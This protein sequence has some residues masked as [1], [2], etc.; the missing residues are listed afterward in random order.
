MNFIQ[1]NK[2]F[3]IKQLR[4]NIL[5]LLISVGILMYSAFDRFKFIYVI[6]ELYII[7]NL[8]LNARFQNFG[9]NKNLEKNQIEIFLIYISIAFL[10]IV[11]SLGNIYWPIYFR[12]IIIISSYLI[13][14]I[15][16][17]T[18]SHKQVIILFF[19]TCLGFLLDKRGLR[20]D[21]IQISVNLFQTSYGEN[22]Y[23][24]STYY[25]IFLIY[26]LSQKKYLLSIL[27]IILVLLAGKRTI[28]FGLIPPLIAFIVFLK[29]NKSILV[30]LYFLFCSIIAININNILSQFFVLIGIDDIDP[31]QVLEGRIEPNLFLNKIIHQKSLINYLF[32]N[33]AGQADITLSIYR[34]MQWAEQYPIGTNPHNDFLKIFYDYGIIGIIS[35]AFIFYL[36]GSKTNAAGKS[37]LVFTATVMITENPLIYIY[38]W[39]VLLMLLFSERIRINPN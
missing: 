25:G 30:A 16:P 6:P 21:D 11:P 19:V 3:E 35:F 4:G 10:S 5:T 29:F 9:L 39:Y 28:I 8:F 23:N 37:F 18:F 2:L 32:G 12:D 17:I 14:F 31:S 7:C 15:F 38:Y 22:E 1:R 27:A 20:L 24:F 13:L 36:L 26:F 34:P 33:G